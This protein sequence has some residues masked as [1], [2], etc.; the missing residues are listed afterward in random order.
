MCHKV[1]ARPTSDLLHLLAE[2]GLRGP[3]L[4]SL[5]HIRSDWGIVEP[6]VLGSHGRSTSAVGSPDPGT[7]APLLENMAS[8]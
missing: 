4:P 1:L 6:A 8:E 2:V 7:P 5:H 3:A